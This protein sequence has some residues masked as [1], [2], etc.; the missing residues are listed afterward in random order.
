MLRRRDELF[1]LIHTLEKVGSIDFHDIK[2]FLR[3]HVIFGNL[4][5]E[6]VYEAGLLGFSKIAVHNIDKHT[7]RNMPLESPCLSSAP[8]NG[9]PPGGGGQPR[10]S[11]PNPGIRRSASGQQMMQALYAD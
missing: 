7:N 10:F 9:T 1:P 3:H 8:P 11:K 2:V 5:V 4:S 6:D